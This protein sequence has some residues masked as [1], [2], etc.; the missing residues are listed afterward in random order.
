MQNIKHF[1]VSR[2]LLIRHSSAQLIQSSIQ[3]RASGGVGLGA[4]GFSPSYY[5]LRG[6]W[7]NR[8]A[9]DAPLIRGMPTRLWE[10]LG[11]AGRV[12]AT[13][14]RPDPPKKRSCATLARKVGRAINNQS[15]IQVHSDA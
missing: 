4:W 15:S 10:F 3:V 14:L 8:P 11:N 2:H 9:P 13:A 5:S 7:V 12:W 6:G 1:N